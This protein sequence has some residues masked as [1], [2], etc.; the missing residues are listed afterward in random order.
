MILAKVIGTVVAD[1]RVSSMG[2][3]LLRLVQL[4]DGRTLEANGGICVAADVTGAGDGE[5]VMLSSGASA[6]KA[7]NLQN[8]PVDLV[9]I[10]IIDELAGA[11]GAI[12][13]STRKDGVV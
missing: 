13:R 9:I 1:A 11:D 10:A 2:G 4:L 8:A 5:L 7:G 6:R 12:Y 3:Q